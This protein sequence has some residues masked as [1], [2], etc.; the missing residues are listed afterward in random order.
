M[1]MRSP[2]WLAAPLAAFAFGLAPAYAAP[3]EPSKITP[4]LI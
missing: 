2:G 4:Q 3:P 1:R